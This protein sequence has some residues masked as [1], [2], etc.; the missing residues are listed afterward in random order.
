MIDVQPLPKPLAAPLAR[1]WIL[2]PKTVFLNH[3]SF[4]ACPEKVLDYQTHIRRVMESE[5]VR[6]F[7]RDLHASLQQAREDLGAFIGADPED[8]VSVANATT[9]VNTVLSSIPLSTGDEVLVTNHEYP[10]CRNAL[11]ARAASSGASVVVADIPFPLESPQEAI[12]AVL[13]KVNPKTRLVLLDHVTSQTA[14][15]MPIE[16]LVNEIESLGIPVLI[17]GAHAPGMIDLN[18]ETIGAS[19]YTGNCHKWLC[20]PKGAAFLWVRKDFQKSIRPLVISHGASAP[21]DEFSRFRLEFDWTGT[22]DPTAFL[23]I[24]TAIKEIAAMVTGGWPEVRR[25]NRNL[26]LKARDILCDS[27]AIDAPCP[28]SMIGSM[29]AV[30]IIDGSPE[31]PKSPLYCDPL[32][33]RLL[34]DLGIEAPIIPWPHPPHRLIRISAQL[35][36]TEEQYRYL[37]VALK[38]LAEPAVA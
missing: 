13:A 7:A 5:P 31:P 15:V 12:D 32:Q 20:S 8:L 14:L 4:G 24:P 6:F 25:L 2:D 33:D 1:H 3:G 23:S 19:F 18:L 29:A 9:G 27:L 36:N 10:A 21:L 28:D 16:T 37:A 38:R 35:Y 11:E 26:A 30:P 34:F 17:D 22:G